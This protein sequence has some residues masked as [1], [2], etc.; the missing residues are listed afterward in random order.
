M[1]R[2]TQAVQPHGNLWGGHC[3]RRKGFRCPLLRVAQG[4][5]GGHDGGGG[6]GLCESES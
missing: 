4:P 2:P 5:L 1:P 6:G 3:C